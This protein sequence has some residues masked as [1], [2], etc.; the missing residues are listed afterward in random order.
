MERNAFSLHGLQFD[1]NR[2]EAE[3]LDQ[4]LIKLHSYEAILVIVLAKM[5]TQGAPQPMSSQTLDRV[6]CGID[7]LITV[8]G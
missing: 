5:I 2:M 7:Q 8:S 3:E 6:R 1:D 4:Y